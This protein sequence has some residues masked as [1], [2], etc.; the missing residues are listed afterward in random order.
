MGLCKTK[1]HFTV[2]LYKDTETCSKIHLCYVLCIFCKIKNSTLLFKG[3][4]KIVQHILFMC[5]ISTYHV[6][7]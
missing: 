6:N 7:I 4:F 3:L 2:V 1:L 5:Q